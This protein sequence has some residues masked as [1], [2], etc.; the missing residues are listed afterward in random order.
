MTK[1]KLPSFWN[2]TFKNKW[3]YIVLGIYFLINDS[4]RDLILWRISPV[5]AVGNVIGLG[6]VIAV[7]F[8]IAY[9]IYRAGY[10]EKTKSL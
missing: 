6:F 3:Y 4:S 8:F 10:N 7:I 2:W 5:A 1:E 9:L